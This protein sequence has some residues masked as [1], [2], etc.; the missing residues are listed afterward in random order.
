MGSVD[1]LGVQHRDRIKG[2]TVERI[3]LRR[4]TGAAHAP[5]VDGDAAI[6]ATEGEALEGPTARVGTETLD[7]EQRRTIA[8]PE[9]VVMNGH[10]VVDDDLGHTDSP[11]GGLHFAREREFPRLLTPC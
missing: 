9:D 5:I 8:A 6:A 11:A 1:V 10:S 4:G 3:R 2:H 7:H